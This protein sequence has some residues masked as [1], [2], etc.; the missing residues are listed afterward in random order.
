MFKEDYRKEM[1]KIAPDSS[2]LQELAVK[3]EQ[4]A[5]S[6]RQ[7]RA[8][9]NG[10]RKKAGRKAL[11]WSTAAAAALI[12]IG[13][14]IRW[15]GTNGLANANDNFMKQNAGGLLEHTNASEGVFDGSSWYGDETKPEEI[16]GILVD[17]M[18]GDKGLKI[19]VS[20]KENFQNAEEMSSKNT[21][22]LVE[23]LA[24][25]QIMGNYKDAKD[26]LVQSPVYYLAEFQDGTVIK[27][28]IYGE[29]Y[30][31]CSEIDGV[32]EL[33]E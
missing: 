22:D 15:K 26:L 28:T 21:A 20:T 27:F 8:N 5:E 2:F 1:Q 18:T 17:K 12:C 33:K 23:R 3:M 32:F 29:K 24:E 19:T 16:F 25:G 9:I 31:F 30:F 11:I 14:G 13:I 4:E 7:E 10:K 6:S